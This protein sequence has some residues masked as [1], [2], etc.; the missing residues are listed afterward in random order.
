MFLV[1]LYIGNKNIE[2]METDDID[3]TQFQEK[4]DRNTE[5]TQVIIHI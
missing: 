1:V 2:I 5:T 4:T 3:E